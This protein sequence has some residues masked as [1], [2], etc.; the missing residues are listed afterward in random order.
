MDVMDL[1]CD[2]SGVTFLS[3]AQQHVSRKC[4]IMRGESRH[5]RRLQ[6]IP[7]W[8]AIYSLTDEAGRGEWAML[9]CTGVC[10]CVWAALQSTKGWSTGM[11][12][13]HDAC[14]CVCLSV[15]ESCEHVWRSWEGSPALRSLGPQETE[16]HAAA[17]EESETEARQ[18]GRTKKLQEVLRSGDRSNAALNPVATHGVVITVHAS[19]TWK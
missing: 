14:V 18:R 8:G 10:E 9:E 2:T 12:V 4:T 16:C 7:E 15:W 17:A 11:R 1:S 13:H 3:D 5:E 6:E 19:N